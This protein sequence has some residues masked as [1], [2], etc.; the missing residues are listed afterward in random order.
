MVCVLEDPRV[1]KLH[2]VQR[3]E[4]Q[5]STLLKSVTMRLSTPYISGLWTT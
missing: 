3:K 2:K 4:S 1:M 5:D